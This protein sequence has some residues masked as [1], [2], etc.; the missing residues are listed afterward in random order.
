MDYGK[1]N[2]STP[3]T[4]FFSFFVHAHL[5]EASTSTNIADGYQSVDIGLLYC[6]SRCDWPTNEEEMNGKLISFKVFGW[7]SDLDVQTSRKGR[8]NFLQDIL[9]LPI[10]F[11]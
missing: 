3:N 2:Y 5:L 4:I 1:M 10:S 8:E 9:T 7:T 11:T 6:S